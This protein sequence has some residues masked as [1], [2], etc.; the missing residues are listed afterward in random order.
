MAGQGNWPLPTGVGFARQRRSGHPAL[1]QIQFGDL[2]NTESLIWSDW[3]FDAPPAAIYSYAPSGGVQSGGV[4][5]VTRIMVAAV[6]GGVQ[7]GGAATIARIMVPSVA[8][9]VQS[10]GSA[11]VARVMVAEVA[12]GV[13]GGGYAD[14]VFVV[15]VVQPDNPAPDAGFLFVPRSKQAPV[16]QFAPRGGITAG[17]YAVSM[18]V[19]AQNN[20]YEFQPSGGVRFT[21]S[22][23]TRLYDSLER[24]RQIDDEEFSL[25]FKVA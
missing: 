14:A 25:L 21:G 17:G 24:V 3:F 9:G 6:A 4:A 1:R 18:F 12:G 16:Y 15:G 5:T 10:G 8:G 7:S 2:D 11:T 23:A 19:A 22:A 20:V 13:Q